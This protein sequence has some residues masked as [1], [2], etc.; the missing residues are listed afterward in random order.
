MN[1]IDQKTVDLIRYLIIITEN[2]AT[3][4]AHYY[5]EIVKKLLKM[6]VKFFSD[7]E[8]TIN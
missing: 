1:L 3:K 7:N 4:I 5:T 6:K 8:C 2:S